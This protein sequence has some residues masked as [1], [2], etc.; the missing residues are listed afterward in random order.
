MGKFD[1]FNFFGADLNNADLTGANLTG[2]NLTDVAGIAFQK[3]HCD[4]GNWS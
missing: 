1:N 3:E 4:S 2:A